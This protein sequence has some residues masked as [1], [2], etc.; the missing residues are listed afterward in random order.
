M[1]SCA[2]PATLSRFKEGLDLSWIKE[3]LPSVW[4]SD[5]TLHI[6]RDGEVTHAPAFLSFLGGRNMPLFTKS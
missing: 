3:V 5:R 1:I 6:T 4:I 2:L